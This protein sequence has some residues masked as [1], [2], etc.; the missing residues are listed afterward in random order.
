MKKFAVILLS[1]LFWAGAGPAFAAKITC[2]VS[3][4]NGDKVSLT[5]KDPG[6]V[7]AGDE[8]KVTQQKKKDVLDGGC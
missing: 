7:N 5:C 8:V 3:A 6:K 4:I 1:V 2:T